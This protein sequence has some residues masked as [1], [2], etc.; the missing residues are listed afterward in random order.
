MATG[1]KYKWNGASA[2]VAVAGLL[3]ATVAACGDDNE[4]N[5]TGGTITM[6]TW[7]ATQS[8]DP[9]QVAGTGN[10]GGAELAALYDT[11]MRYDPASGAF[12]PQTAESLTPNDDF[13]QWTLTLRSGITFSDGAPYDS[14]AV[15]AN[16]QRHTEARS[17]ASSLVAPITDYATPD[18]LTVVF[19]LAFPWNNFP[20]ALAGTPGMVV[21]PAAVA[22]QGDAFGT[23]PQDAGAGPFVFDEFRP[24]ESLTLTRNP[25]Y[26]GGEVPLDGVRFIHAGDGPQTYEAF[27]AG[28]VDLAFLRDAGAIADAEADGAEGIRVQYSAND[29]LI[30]N[31]G[32]PITC[33][34]G[35]PAPRCEDQPDGTELESTAPTAD[36]R[37]RQAVAAAIDLETLKQR[38][39]GGAGF[40]S[41]ALISEDSRWYDG[42]EGP[43]YDIER[44][45]DLVEQAKA[46]GWDGRIRV[47]CHTGL[48]TWGTAVQGMLEAAGMQVDLTDQQ[49]IAANTSAVIVRKDFDLACFGSS[50]SD[51]E[52][53]FALNR[54]FN[55]TY[56]TTGGGNFSGYVNP[57][58][59][60]AIAA[61]RGAGSEAEVKAAISTIA[62]AYAE[63]V[64]F[65][66]LTA[67]PE[68]VLISDEVGDVLQSVN[69]VVLLGRATRG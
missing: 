54:D 27:R 32:F 44:A 59:D 25:D 68:V 62:R 22:A 31:N 21:N 35:E 58:V 13:T 2:R 29:T 69:T 65:L 6:A 52:P 67:Q 5:E 60:E 3:L 37:V 34:E 45:R 66:A 40:M 47:S 46:D 53:F 19:T 50:I 28:S 9:V 61:G 36:K 49:E 8:L 1:R 57:T 30:M 63:D 12:E 41:S 55:S 11:I 20:F 14:A 23:N 51:A 26:W 56:V 17:N 43:A 18:D 39:Y 38:V 4:T 33:Q 64:P 16:L 10:S 42:V 24:D 48:P 15:V 7:S